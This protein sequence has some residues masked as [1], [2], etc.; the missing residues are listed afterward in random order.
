MAEF[1]E[2]YLDE[3]SD[4]EVFEGYDP[5]EILLSE[6]RAV[7]AMEAI[8]ADI[9]A[10]EQDEDEEVDDEVNNDLTSS[11]CHPWLVTFPKT[12]GPVNILDGSD[13]C[14]IFSTLFPEPVIQ[15]LV[16]QTNK[17]ARDYL[18]SVTLKP[19]SRAKSWVETTEAE[20]KAFL[21]LILL[22][23]IH[24]LPSYSMYWSTNPLLW[25]K[26]G[27]PFSEQMSR[28]RFLLLLRFLHACDNGLNTGTDRMYKVRDV[29]QCITEQWQV[30][31]QPA[32]DLS[33][34][35]SLIPFKGRTAMK[36]YIP[37]KPHKW[38]LKRWRLCESTT[39]IQAAGILV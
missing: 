19:C 12:P 4:D 20:M 35:E 29:V 8:E 34:D 6:Q 27:S 24:K 15:I 37:S 18:E 39:G 25:G 30:H 36:Q 21:A 23:G 26:S 17:Y 11:Y 38:G 16:T 13:E 33:V 28:N 22:M 2:V 7:T 32:R 31:Y 5:S 14:Q 9:A 1:D 10:L 3:M